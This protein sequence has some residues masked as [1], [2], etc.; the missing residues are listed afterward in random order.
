MEPDHESLVHELLKFRNSKEAEEE[1]GEEEEGEEEEGEE[2]EKIEEI[3]E[4][5]AKLD[6]DIGANLDIV[7]TREN[8]KW[9]LE[10]VA[11]PAFAQLFSHLGREEDLTGKGMQ[12]IT[13]DLDTDRS[14]SIEEV[15]NIITSKQSLINPGFFKRILNSLLSDPATMETRE[16][17]AR[18]PASKEEEEEIKKNL[19]DDIKR[20][21]DN[22]PETAE[23]Q[24]LQERHLKLGCGDTLRRT[25]S[26]DRHH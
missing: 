7:V 9:I 3:I 17:L 2:E 13:I 26:F 22:L 6:T 25:K 12:K 23:L 16:Q 10:I 19:C 18:V 14:S 24:E 1:E 5:V 8:Q 11:I 4:R 21:L 15:E 20:D